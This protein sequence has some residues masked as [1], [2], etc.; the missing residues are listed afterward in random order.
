[1]KK[2]PMVV[3]LVFLFC[4]AFGC[5]Q[6]SDRFTD[7]PAVDV[8]ADKEAIIA[9]LNN[10]ASVISAEDLD[11]WLSLFTENAIFMNP[12]AE[13][14][15][16]VEASRM[17]ATPVFQQ[18]DHEIGITIDEVEVS[19]NWAFARW[20][21]TWKFTPKADG[22]TME[23]NGKEL[24]IFK[25]QADSSWKCS[26]IIWNTNTPPPIPSE[27]VQGEEVIREFKTVM[28]V[29][30]DVEPIKDWVVGNFS[31]ADSGDLEGYL[32]FWA[33][34]VVWMPPNAP[35]VQGKSAIKEFVRPFFELYTIQRNFSIEEIEMDGNY[36]FARTISEET[37]TPQTG[38]G[39]PMKANSKG[40]FLLR[41]ISGGT[42]L[43]THCI[44]N[45]NDPLPSSE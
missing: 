16:G 31:A 3:P 35:I 40:L 21:F 27:E 41:H 1:M 22:D 20:S 5:Q 10:N 9:L 25:R 33:E 37:Y 11:G 39:E 2:L 28:N 4:F 8:E 15:R 18:F 45:S 29:E 42:W 43:C 14:L 30:A 7:E 24:W 26:H 38:E 6:Q 19:S 34:D 23:E 32:S 17:Y 44:W 13:T 36:A 12:N